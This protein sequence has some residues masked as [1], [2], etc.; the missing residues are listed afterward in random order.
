VAKISR[1]EVSAKDQQFELT[2]LAAKG[3]QTAAT[4]LFWPKVRKST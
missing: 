1:E 3:V 4:G 2:Q